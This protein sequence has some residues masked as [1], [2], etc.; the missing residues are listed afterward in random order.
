LL[1]ALA[2]FLSLCAW[3]ALLHGFSSQHNEVA[4]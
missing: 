1:P 4:R 3:D 2:D